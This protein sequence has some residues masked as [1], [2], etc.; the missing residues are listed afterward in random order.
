MTAAMNATKATTII[1]EDEADQR[2][3]MV[4]MMRTM[5]N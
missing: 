1:T 2:A 4:M 3:T 5:T